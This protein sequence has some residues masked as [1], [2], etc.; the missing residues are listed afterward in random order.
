VVTLE[1]L[2]ALAQLQHLPRDF[3]D[4]TGLPAEQLRLWHT[5]NL[6][7]IIELNLGHKSGDLSIRAALQALSGVDFS[8]EP[9]NRCTQIWIKDVEV[10]EPV[11]DSDLPFGI[12]GFSMDAKDNI[13]DMED[14]RFNRDFLTLPVK[15]LN[16]TEKFK[17]DSFEYMESMKT[18]NEYSWRAIR[19]GRDS[20]SFSCESDERSRK[21]GFWTQMF[22]PRAPT[23][24]PR[25]NSHR[26]Y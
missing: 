17:K 23:T 2:N 13:W 21:A 9:A 6:K 1:K 5:A 3:A 19:F 7:R 22:L 12:I 26:S 15:E 14:K 4:D 20:G 10:F 18:A 16:I 11:R 25:M 24:K 8:L